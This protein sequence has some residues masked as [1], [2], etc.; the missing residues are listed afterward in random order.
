[1]LHHN[2]TRSAGM[3][4]F[5]TPKTAMIKPPSADISRSIFPSLEEGRD[6]EHEFVVVAV[7]LVVG[8]GN[9]HPYFKGKVF[10]RCIAQTGRQLMS[11]FTSWSVG[12]EPLSQGRV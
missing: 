5:R 3:H 6:S 8:H 7:A 4:F 10:G 11:D 9:R 1:M 12:M 2:I